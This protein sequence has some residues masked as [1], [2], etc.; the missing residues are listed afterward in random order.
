[1]VRRLIPLLIL[2]AACTEWPFDPSGFEPFDPPDY[3]AEWYAELED[4]M[5]V[6]GDFE[7][8]QWLVL[9]GTITFPCE[10]GGEAHECYGVWREP[11][12]IYLSSVVIGEDWVDIIKH[13]MLHELL[14]LSGHPEPPFGTCGT[15]P[16]PI[17]S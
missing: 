14:Q 2:V 11:H 12:R 5:G 8:I 15:S 3:F 17:W 10:F 1:M 4:C 16:G 6:Q 13:E 9:P 7:R